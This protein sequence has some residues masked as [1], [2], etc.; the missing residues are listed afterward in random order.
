[1]KK[2]LKILATGTLA[3]MLVALS[4]CGNSQQGRQVAGYGKQKHYE[5]ELYAQVYGAVLFDDK[6]TTFPSMEEIKK[7]V[8]EKTASSDYGEMIQ[9]RK[10]AILLQSLLEDKL[11]SIA[12]QEKVQLDDEKK[13]AVKTEVE[14]AK[15][16]FENGE[17]K[18]QIKKKLFADASDA[19]QKATEYMENFKTFFFTSR[20][21]KS[22][23]EYEKKVE[24]RLL[25]EKLME[26]KGDKV[27]DDEQAIKAYYDQLLGEQQK[28]YDANKASLSADQNM[29]IP[30]VYYPAGMRRVKHILV[31]FAKADP[32]TPAATP[33]EEAKT[34]S[35]AEEIQGKIKA[36]ENFDALLEQYG[37]DPGMKEGSQTLIQGGYLVF[38]GQGEYY[39]EFVDGAMALKKVGDV[40]APVK[41]TSGYHLIQ[42]TSEVAAGPVAYESI[43]EELTS[44]AMSKDRQKAIDD[45]YF[46]VAKELLSDKE[47]SIDYKTLGLKQE[48]LKAFLE[49]EF[50][51]PAAQEPT[52]VEE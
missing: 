33:E 27:S 45:Y 23:E 18:E 51:Q 31:A 7:E 32:N 15:S 25:S 35:K 50:A 11:Y 24:K 28:S 14:D 39:K 9:A 12:L 47:L 22:F 29:K 21:I 5:N 38:V 40:S 36:G 44:S 3:V 34:K 8:D 4:A 46:S 13:N 49:K 48:D 16:Y 2:F 26:S 37:E 43:K 20:G 30:I 10:E 52:N 1:M 6:K 19:E 41:S 42:Y 17:A